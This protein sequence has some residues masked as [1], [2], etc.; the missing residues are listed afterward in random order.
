M[1][2]YSLADT[3]FMKLNSVYSL[4]IPIDDIIVNIETSVD[5]RTLYLLSKF[6]FCRRNQLAAAF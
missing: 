4:I 2:L 3:C 5:S 1:Q 6:I